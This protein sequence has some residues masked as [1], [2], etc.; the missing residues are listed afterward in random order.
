MTNC[1]GDKRC[2]KIE[3][4]LNQLNYKRDYFLSMQFRFC[5]LAQMLAEMEQ[6]LVS[7]CV[8][9]TLSE[10]WQIH[11]TV[12][13]RQ[14]PKSF[15]SCSEIISLTIGIQVPIYLN[16]ALSQR[17]LCILWYALNYCTAA[18]HGIV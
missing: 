3:N 13:Q 8:F 2:K 1:N 16:K 6:E 18:T 14:F 4:I 15:Q 5:F 9:L 17:I 11:V 10:D 7:W 12:F